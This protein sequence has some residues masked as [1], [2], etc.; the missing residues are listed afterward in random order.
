[1][2]SPPFG[3]A[4]HSLYVFCPEWHCVAQRWSRVR[5]PEARSEWRER[6]AKWRSGGGACLGVLVPPSPPPSFPP[7]A[8]LFA[9]L[10]CAIV[11]ALLI[12]PLL[13][14]SCLVP[15]TLICQSCPAVHCHPKPRGGGEKKR[16]ECE[17]VGRP[18]GNCAKGPVERCKATLRF[19]LLSFFLP[20]SVAL[21]CYCDPEQSN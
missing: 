10:T 2:Q 19:F 21:F 11:R 17:R 12:P 5:F 20:P 13:L 3:L 8:S 18:P 4:S 1:M 6:V 9:F 16:E 15:L 7:S 14:F